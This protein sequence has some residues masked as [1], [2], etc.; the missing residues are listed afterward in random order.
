MTFQEEWGAHSKYCM[1]ANWIDVTQARNIVSARL[2]AQAQEKYGL[3]T[4]TPN[5]GEIDGFLVEVYIND[6]YHGLYTLNIPK[7]AW[8]WGLDKKNENH[9][10]MMA[11]VT[12]TSSSVGFVREA[13]A[14]NGKE[15]EI[16]VDPDKTQEDVEHCFEKLNRLIRFV[17]DS[18]DEEFVEQF[19]D[20]LN[21]DA[22]LNY[23]CFLY[24][25]NA[26]DNKTKNMILVTFDGDVWYPA[27]YD[28]DATW[29]I[30]YDG[31]GLLYPY[32]TFP[33][34]QNTCLLWDRLA[35]LFGTEIKE[36]YNHLCSTVWSKENIEAALTDFMTSVP[37]EVYDRDRG[38]WPELQNL[39]GS[40]E[41]IIEY[42]DLREGYVTSCIDQMDFQHGDELPDGMLYQ[43]QEP[44]QGKKYSFRNTGVNLFSGEAELNQNFTILLQYCDSPE[45]AEAG[46]MQTILSNTDGD[47][48]GLTIETNGSNYTMFYAGAR[49]YEA[50]YHLQPQVYSL[51]IVKEGD[52]YT[53][54][55]DDVNNVRYIEGTAGNVES[56]A[57]LYLA[58]QPYV[59]SNGS[60]TT[61]N[62]FTGMIYQ[63]EILDHALTLDETSAIMREMVAA[64]KNYQS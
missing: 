40:L 3:F 14:E 49:Q 8:V 16:E 46:K 58:G 38:A 11:N 47:M 9:I 17:K 26:T 48:S 41:Q 43:L 30:Y 13:P 28:L 24:R 18:S 55:A 50:L 5:N 33:Q 15:W 25:S 2:Y 42:S 45:N 32:D 60:V 6:A 53:F 19:Q 37:Q 27:L 12:D 63:C 29:G 44:L 52:S 62:N 21:L 7:A 36:R 59:H 54:Y 35:E 57:N 31:T 64:A 56:E 23:Y 61:Y 10:A 51:I 34:N 39:Y 4:D 20:Y 1:K 22:C